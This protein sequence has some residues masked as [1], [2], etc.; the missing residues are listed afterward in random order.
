MKE[1]K[2]QQFRLFHNN[3]GQLLTINV[4]ENHPI[5]PEHDSQRLFKHFSYINEHFI[6]DFMDDFEIGM[7]DIYTIKA[8]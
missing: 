1:I 8:L 4:I 2:L 5:N 3:L 6:V 7:F